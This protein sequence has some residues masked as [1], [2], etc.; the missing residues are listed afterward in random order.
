[1]NKGMKT[2][3]TILGAINVVFNIFTPIAIGLLIVNLFNLTK[4]NFVLILLVSIIS[5]I[6]RAIDV[7]FLKWRK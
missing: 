2:I 5:T 6:Y 7:G 3:V 4:F 1:M